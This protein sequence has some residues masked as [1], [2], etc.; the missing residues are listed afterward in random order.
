MS[1]TTELTADKLKRGES[2]LF[3]SGSS[4]FI[5]SK[6]TENIADMPFCSAIIFAGRTRIDPMAAARYFRL[7]EPMRPESERRA[8]YNSP[9]ATQGSS[10]IHPSSAAF[11]TTFGQRRNSGPK[12]S[13]EQSQTS[14][15]GAWYQ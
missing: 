4:C 14:D 11:T 13:F 6:T 5:S 2:S 8:F 7:A 15:D 1:A 12:H 10:F 3:E 9:A